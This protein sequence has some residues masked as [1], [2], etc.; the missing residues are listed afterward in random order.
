[1][2]M[3]R[4]F[5][6]ILTTLLIGYLLG[7]FFSLKP[8]SFVIKFSKRPRIYL[9]KLNLFIKNW[10]DWIFVVL[11]VFVVVLFLF[12]WERQFNPENTIQIL[13]VIGTFASVLFST[14]IKDNASKNRNKAEID[15][16]FNFSEPDCHQTITHTGIPVTAY[17]SIPT[18]YIRLRVINKGKETLKKAEV[19]L[20]RVKKNNIFLETYLPLN[21]I[22]ALTEVQFN[23]G[24]VEIPQGMFRTLDIFKVR[25]PPISS[26]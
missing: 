2:D 12:F 11:V 25:I 16:K 20:E 4:L 8:V 13:I 22:W 15:I 21:L 17:A 14:L 9:E 18:Y 19:I 1:M 3:D 24:V 26:L 5:L 6:Q 10:N 23:R 7:F